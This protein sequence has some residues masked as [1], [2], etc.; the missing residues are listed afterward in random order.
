[1]E[2]PQHPIYD[3]RLTRL[4]I[5]KIK[6]VIKSLS[7]V[8]QRM[9]TIQIMDN[10]QIQATTGWRS[11]PRSGAGYWIYLERTEGDFRV[12]NVARWVS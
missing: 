1:M 11:G 9:L 12:V 10:E 8:P 4:D 3:P 2:E 7:G 6:R 5:R